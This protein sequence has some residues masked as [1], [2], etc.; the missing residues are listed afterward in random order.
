MTFH[1]LWWFNKVIHQ[2]LTKHNFSEWKN[3]TGYEYNYK[4]ICAFS[5][6]QFY[7]RWGRN[8]EKRPMKYIWLISKR[9][10][11]MNRIANNVQYLRWIIPTKNKDFWFFNHK[12]FTKKNAGAI[13]PEFKLQMMESWHIYQRL[14][15]LV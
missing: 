6:R 13:N 11:L 8:I 2:I 12:P 10:K 3:G 5:L 15:N 14:F 7:S 9:L 4:K 1:C